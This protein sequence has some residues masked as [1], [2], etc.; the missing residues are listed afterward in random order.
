MVPMQMVPMQM[1]PMQMVP[2]QMVRPRR[3]AALRW[4]W[5]SQ[6]S[7]GGRGPSKDQRVGQL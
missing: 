2:M 3:R 1:V 7:Q 6:L 4:S 5:E